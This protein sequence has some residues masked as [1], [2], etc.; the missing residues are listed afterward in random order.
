MKVGDLVRRVW[1]FSE[2]ALWKAIKPPGPG[3]YKVTRVLEDDDGEYISLQ[4][5]AG[6]ATEASCPFNAAHFLVV[7]EEEVSHVFTKIYLHGSCEENYQKGEELGLIGDALSK[8]RYALYEVEFELKV[9]VKTG[10]YKILRVNGRELK[11]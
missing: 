6:R 5:Q 7:G 11:E 1:F 2:N 4:G 9:D 8:F 3:P 10:E